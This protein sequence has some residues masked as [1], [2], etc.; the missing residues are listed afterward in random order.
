MGQHS[1]ADGGGDHGLGN[2][3]AASCDTAALQGSASINPGFR[4]TEDECYH[5]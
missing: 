1:Q 5:A 2:H 3:P 4:R